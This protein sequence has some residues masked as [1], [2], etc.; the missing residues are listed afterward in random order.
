MF[1]A[2]CRNYRMRQTVD[3][4]LPRSCPSKGSGLLRYRSSRLVA[5]G[6]DW[7]AWLGWDAVYRSGTLTAVDSGWRNRI[8]SVGKHGLPKNDVEPLLCC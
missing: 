5:L 4:R 7:I 6:E 2:L 1:C 3:D 8:I